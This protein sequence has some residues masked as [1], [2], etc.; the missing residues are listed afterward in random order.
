MQ[1]VFRF[2]VLVTRST[3]IILTLVIQW[4]KHGKCFISNCARL[5]VYKSTEREYI[6]INSGLVTY[7]ELILLSL[8]IVATS[9]QRLVPVM[10]HQMQKSL[11][12]HVVFVIA[13]TEANF[14]LSLLFG[15]DIWASKV[16]NRYISIVSL[17]DSRYNYCPLKQNVSDDN[18]QD[19][20]TRHSHNDDA[21]LPATMELPITLLTVT[22]VPPMAPTWFLKTTMSAMSE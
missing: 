2:A 19:D 10:L 18:T 5:T 1:N 16:D 22:F 12:Q 6:L 17:A 11:Q 13:L 7:K 21:V 4:G 20:V 8:V 14:V 15:L 9:W 3:G